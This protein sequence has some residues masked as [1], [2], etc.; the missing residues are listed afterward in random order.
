MESSLKL[1][2][3]EHL[4]QFL[5]EERLHLF[6]QKLNERSNR[7]TLV[8]E[9]VF[10]SRNISA[11]MRSADC[12]GIQNIHIIENKNN[13]VKDKSVSLGAG[14]WINIKQYNT[15]ENNTINCLKKLK[16]EG[17][18]IIATSPHN[19]NISLDEIDVKNNKI[20]IILGTELTGLSEKALSFADKRMKINMYGFTESLNI[21]VS[22]AICCQSISSKMRKETTGWEVTEEEKTDILL[23]WIRNS[24]KSGKQIEEKFLDDKSNK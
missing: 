3:I 17:Y 7:I 2:L 18:Q 6:Q 10:Q 16:K 12:F 21:S 5:T 14:K 13:F 11:A 15:E 24:I 9:D 22:A 4:S 8:L 23:N 20:A 19:T 1:E